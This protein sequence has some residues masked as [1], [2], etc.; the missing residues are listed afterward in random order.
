MTKAELIERYSELYEKY[1]E[2]CTEAVVE[3][4][5]R[6]QLSEENFALRSKLEQATRSRDALI[7]Q[8]SLEESVSKANP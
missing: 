1:T 6:E 8:V 7:Y 3:R 5:K 4:K 2:A